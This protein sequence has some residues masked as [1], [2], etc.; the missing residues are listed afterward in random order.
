MNQLK[1]IEDCY[2]EKLL[3]KVRPSP[4][5]ARESLML[6]SAYLDEARLVIG[7]GANRMSMSG[8]YMA[9]FHAARAIL[10]RDGIREK[11]HYCIQLYLDTYA[12]AGLLE[13]EWVLMFGRMRTQRHDSQYSFAPAP[14]DK[15]V[16]AAILYAEQF[17]NRINQILSD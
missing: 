6:A 11:N 15:E 5:K 12:K 4:E 2:E 8:A 16:N 1:S 3:R 14:A 13:E 7:V 17:V 9:W 10:F